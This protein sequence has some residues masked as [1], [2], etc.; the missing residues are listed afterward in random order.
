LTRPSATPPAP[1]EKPLTT[2]ALFDRFRLL[3]LVLTIVTTVFGITAVIHGDRLADRSEQATTQVQLLT[4]VDEA[5]TAIAADPAQL[6]EPEAAASFDQQ[7]DQVYDQLFTA[8]AAGASGDEST[9]LRTVFDAT[10]DF[11]DT[12]DGLI[13][14]AQTEGAEAVTAA[15]GEATDQLQQ[16]AQQPL[17]QLIDQTQV[18]AAN[19]RP[20]GLVALGLIAAGL[21]LGALLMTMIGGA[22]RTHRVLNLWWVGAAAAETG[23]LVQIAALLTGVYPMTFRIVAL[24][25]TGLI[26]LT[27]QLLGFQ[28]RLKEY[29]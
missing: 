14:Q 12:I 24:T 25:A 19:S 8:T 17:E 28:S 10:R 27:L 4:D 21:S 3:G 7:L 22:R 23:L 2:P 1:A 18:Q 5:L 6:A 20:I 11:D 13:V 15:Y 29:R 9:V 16:Q 26:A